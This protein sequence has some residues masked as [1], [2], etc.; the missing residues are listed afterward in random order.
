[1]TSFSTVLFV[2]LFS[3]SVAAQDDPV[4]EA[5]T[6]PA[7]TEGPVPEE[8][9][10]AEPAAAED[11]E[12]AAAE[13]PEPAAAEDPE[14]AATELIAPTLIEDV[15]P[16]YPEQARANGVSGSVLLLITIDEEGGVADAEVV[17]TPDEVLSLASLDASRRLR[18][19]PATQAGQPVSVQ[20]HYRFSFAL[21]I[22]DQGGNAVP[23]SLHGFV[24]DPDGLGIPNVTV[25]ITSIDDAAAQPTVVTVKPDGSFWASFLPSGRYTATV[26]HSSFSGAEVGIEIRAGETLERTFTL[27]PFGTSEMVVTYETQTWREV[28]RAP[29]EVNEGTVTSSY[30]LTRR[31]IEATPGSME[32]VARAVHSLPGVVSDGDMLASFH[33]RGGETN[34]V[35]FMLDRVPLNNPF[36]LAGFNSLFNPDMISGVDFYAGAA[37]ADVPAG[38]SA[39]LAVQSWDGS[40]KQDSD[41]MDGAVDISAS[42]LRAHLMGP[43]S[44]STSIAL[45][46]RRS[47]ME[48]YF[49]VMKWANLIDTAFAAPEFSEV[50]ARFAWK[51][52]GQHRLIATVMRSGDS[53]GLVDSADESV[54]SV[55]GSLELDNR[56][57]LF[58]L[59]HKYAASDTLTVWTTTAWTYDKSFMRRDLGGKYNHDVGSHRWFGRTDIYK[60]AGKHELA[61]GVD[62][63][64][65]L[66][67]AEG[68]V[69]DARS[70]PTWFGAPISEYD[71][72][73]MVFDHEAAWPEGA[74]YL[75]DTWGGPVKVRLG[76][77]ATRTGATDEWLLSPRAGLSVPLPSGTVPKVSWG[78]YHKTPHEP[79][80]LDEVFGNPD[81]KSET[82]S[83]YI[84]GIDQGFPLPGEDSGGL[85]RVEGY[86]IDLKDLVVN[87]D[88]TAAVLAGTSYTNDGSGTSK[89][90]DTLV[91]VQYKRLQYRVSYSLLF[92][93]RTN[94]LNEIFAQ[95]IAP[96]QDQ[97]HTVGTSIEYQATPRWRTTARFAFHSG[98][99]VSSVRA[100]DNEDAP[101]TVELSCLNCARLGA[102]NAID[103]RAEWRKAMRNYRLSFY[104]EV[105]NV[106]NF[107]SDF[108]PIVDIEDGER[109]NSMLRH[110]PARPF[111]G[112]RA[113]F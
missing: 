111:L 48:S 79:L 92:A 37:P 6:G 98:R 4:G 73:V 85:I 9:P 62:Y 17:S 27:F 80:L 59:D 76:G 105:L 77:R 74:V 82:A 60:T 52:N 22:A 39:V 45:A 1:M 108:V 50:S 28:E 104:V 81:L 66:V 101:D 3:S 58:S 24:Q 43:I 83:H 112:L 29:L 90:V 57:S 41:D 86:Y 70:E 33:A 38:T 71:Q 88:N 16:V 106:T 11:P 110:L 30:K 91:G 67:D 35:V 63:S 96:A 113:D 42:S 87:P 54:I 12:P 69:P 99:P 100:S 15:K 56:L 84:V 89:G 23:G 93:E 25:R 72:P 2:W 47:Y 14:P 53:L 40:G 64:W 103:L 75:Q 94:P 13:D 44:D 7:D 20:I 49:Q 26:E 68:R 10:L 34:D 95:T 97:R 55:E 61:G 36:H 65:F 5:P 8:A 21:G 107:K 31:D 18:F 19:K 78:I 51:P 102:Y 46:A 109:T 32:D